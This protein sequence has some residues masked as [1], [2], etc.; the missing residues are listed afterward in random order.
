MKLKEWTDERYGLHL[1]RILQSENKTFQKKIAAIHKEID[2]TNKIKSE[3]AKEQNILKEKQDYI[4]ST[5]RPKLLQ[6]ITSLVNNNYVVGQLIEQSA[7]LTGMFVEIQKKIKKQ[8]VCL[9]SSLTA[10]NREDFDVQEAA[11][12]EETKSLELYEE[13]YD[14]YEAYAGILKNTNIDL[15]SYEELG[16]LIQRLKSASLDK[17]GK[18]IIDDELAIFQ[19][20]RKFVIMIN[21]Y[22]NELERQ[23][24]NIENFCKML[25]GIAVTKR[26]ILPFLHYFIIQLSRSLDTETEYIKRIM[27]YENFKKE[28]FQSLINPVEMEIDSSDRL[29]QKSEEVEETLRAIQGIKVK[30]CNH[31]PAGVNPPYYDIISQNDQRYRVFPLSKIVLENNETKVDAPELVNYVI[32]EELVDFISKLREAGM[33]LEEKIRALLDKNSEYRIIV[34]TMGAIPLYVIMRF[35]ARSIDEKKVFYMPAS[36]KILARGRTVQNYFLN[37]FKEVAKS[38]K[39]ITI[40]LIDEIVSGASSSKLLQSYNKAFSQYMK[41]SERRQE[42]CALGNRIRSELILEPLKMLANGVSGSEVAAI[43]EERAEKFK[44]TYLSDRLKG[45]ISDVKNDKVI[46]AAKHIKSDKIDSKSSCAQ[47][48]GALCQLVREVVTEFVE[49]KYESIL[50][51]LLLDIYIIG[52][53]DIKDKPE[54]SKSEYVQ[55]IKNCQAK[56]FDVMRLVLMDN[57][58]LDIAAYK[59]VEHNILDSRLKGNEV[60]LI[61]LDN[62]GFID[63]LEKILSLIEKHYPK[64]FE[65]LMVGTKHFTDLDIHLRRILETAHL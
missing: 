18:R 64:D 26:K 47:L 40:I 31:S 34:P 1:Q 44:I 2:L 50:N 25:K 28:F 4:F 27:N 58:E 43:I 38:G 61:K 7:E 17:E 63:Y 45:F 11:I 24:R 46:I 48:W 5:L 56:Q 29:V 35:F 42:I 22:N 21:D 12:G 20:I 55:M 32:E 53:H 39:K 52:I 41:V 65:K 57:E 30:S 37:V 54:K 8:M 9:K 33:H 6:I 51:S 14:M 59:Q 19:E 49:K 15:K 3:V 13:L 23:H 36:S 16:Q 62:E 10:L 60:E